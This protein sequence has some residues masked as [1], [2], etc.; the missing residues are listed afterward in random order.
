MT[1]TWSSDITQIMICAGKEAVLAEKKQRVRFGAT[2]TTGFS[3]VI[4]PEDCA[5][6]EAFFTAIQVAWD[7][8]WAAVYGASPAGA[9]MH[10]RRCPWALSRRVVA[11]C[12]VR[13]CAVRTLPLH[14]LPGI[15]MLVA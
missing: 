14:R 8:Q 1:Q 2:L 10:Q 13:P 5:D 12:V 7:K 9:S 15:G 6:F 11:A 4:R 3:G